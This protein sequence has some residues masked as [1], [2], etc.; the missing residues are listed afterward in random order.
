MPASIV[1]PSPTSSARMHALRERRLQSEQRGFDLVRV[2]VH[3]RVEQRHRQSIHA[4]RRPTGQ[5]VREVLGVV[6]GQLHRRRI[7]IFR[8]QVSWRVFDSRFSVA[9]D[10]YWY[11]HGNDRVLAACKLGSLLTFAHWQHP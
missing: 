7:R 5:V 6:R 4:A 2:E 8:R 11:A 9:D 1:F 10:E 3:R